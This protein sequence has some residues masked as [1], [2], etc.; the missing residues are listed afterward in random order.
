M[1]ISRIKD[2]L[3]DGI[4]PEIVSQR[5]NVVIQ[6]VNEIA[7]FNGFASLVYRVTDNATMESKI[8]HIT[9]H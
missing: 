2:A 3:D 9:R 6:Y 1:N 5:H 4:H 7:G 8:I